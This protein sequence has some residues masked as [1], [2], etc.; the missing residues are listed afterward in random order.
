MSKK[1]LQKF[2]RLVPKDCRFKRKMS[3]TKL[4]GEKVRE[5]WAVIDILDDAECRSKELLKQHTENDVKSSEP[6]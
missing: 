1:L 5:V 6:A 3:K 4:D 2:N